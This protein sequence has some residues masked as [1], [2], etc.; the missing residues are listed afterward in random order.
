MVP[1]YHMRIA[2]PYQRGQNLKGTIH[3]DTDNPDQFTIQTTEKLDGIVDFCKAKREA[4]KGA[5]RDGLFHVAEVPVSVYEKAV[6]EGWDNPDG[7]K[8]WLNDPDNAIFR[9]REGRV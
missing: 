5:Y 1:L 4:T 8:R 6:Q 9:V 2:I 7:W 3:A